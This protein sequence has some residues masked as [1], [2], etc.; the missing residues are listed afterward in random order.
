MER[1]QNCDRWPTCTRSDG[2]VTSSCRRRGLLFRGVIAVFVL[3]LMS[4]SHLQG[5]D[6]VTRSGDQFMLYGRPFQF[7]GANA[8]Y[9]PSLASLADTQSVKEVLTDASALGMKVIRMWAFHE[10]DDTLDPTV[11]QFSPGVFNER[12]LRGLD[13]VLWQAEAHSFRVILALVGN[14][15][16]FGGMNQ[17]VRWRAQ[18]PQ[19]GAAE[20]E[21]SKDDLGI[22]I[23]G[24][25]GRSYKKA[26]SEEFGHDDFY[27]DPII[28]G[29]YKQYLAFLTN[30]ANTYTGRMYKDDPTIL[31]WELANEPRS[32]DGSGLTVRSWLA[33]M[34][35]Y[36]K[37]IDPLHLVGSGEEGFDVTSVH[38]SLSSYHQQQWLFDGTAGV[39]FSSNLEIPSLDFASIHL[40]P[41][42]WNLWSNSGNAWIQDH[43]RIANTLNKPLIVGEFGARRFKETTYGSWLSTA[44]AENA[45]GAL[46]WQLLDNRRSD[47]DG[48]G[49]RCPEEADVCE[50]LRRAS[51]DFDATTGYTALLAAGFTVKQNYP[52]PF[53]AQTVVEYTLPVGA[54]VTVDLWNTIGQ[55]VMVVYEGFQM[56]GVRRQLIN[57]EDLASG[58]YFIRVSAQGVSS[59]GFERFIDTR[60]LLHLK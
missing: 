12:A 13:Y 49:I 59:K 53:N 3:V 58:A 26:I 15:D 2:E 36:L 22:T 8:Y 9:L 25:H 11:I 30:R 57:A 40:Y 20:Q 46:V 44:V 47:A 7:I 39:S 55:L 32:S 50:I 10:S 16:D 56:P 41:D 23:T 42:F 14:W 31:G 33:D 17:Y 48:F 24:E 5:G 21:F 35:S 29:W 27:T 38:Y 37:S 1:Q 4:S 60:P 28:C 18:M 54:Y 43:V 51:V 19:V 6:F 52:N 34:S 45:G